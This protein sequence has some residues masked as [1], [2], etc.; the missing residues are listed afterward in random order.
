[1]ARI[2]ALLPDP[3]AAER[4]RAAVAVNRARASLGE[5]TFASAWGDL[6]R[7][8]RAHPPDL[9][10]FDPDAAVDGVE[11]FGQLRADQPA[12]ALLP[13]GRFDGGRARVLLRLSLV[14]VRDVVIR[15]RDD[16]PDAI[17]DR[18]ARSLSRRVVDTVCE[19]VSDLFP[20]PLRPLLQYL[21]ENA[22]TPLDPA[23]A[24]RS[25]YCHPKTLRA[26]LRQAG[27][28][29]LN[30]LIVWT[31]LFYAAH[32]L[33]GTGRSAEQV[34]RVLGYPSAAALRAQVQRYARTHVRE[35][36]G[37]RG[38]ELL[39]ERFRARCPADRSSAAEPALEG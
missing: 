12:V 24:A 14:G 26:R 33:A 3:A 32:L 17:R 35:L 6:L 1:M 28:P 8:A 11:G 34:A 16:E 4:L 7:Q 10:V 22:C 2:L 27:L 5:L 9:V 38:L 39:L 30:R 20:A 21:L 37:P 36:R 18:V 19:R 13:Y 23:R 25:Q 15:G 31:R 29:S